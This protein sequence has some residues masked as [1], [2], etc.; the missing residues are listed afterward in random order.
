MQLQVTAF[1]VVWDSIPPSCILF[2][3][4][5]DVDKVEKLCGVGEY[6][7]PKVSEYLKCKT[8]KTRKWLFC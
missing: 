3:V 6:V 1:F 8:N 4:T 5:K 7:D 2:S